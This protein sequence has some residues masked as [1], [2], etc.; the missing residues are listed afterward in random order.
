MQLLSTGPHCSPLGLES[1]RKNAIN[2]KWTIS[3]REI[4]DLF[5]FIDKQ[6]QHDVTEA[7]VCV[8]AMLFVQEMS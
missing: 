8:H 2:F 3:L 6:R 7:E 1:P 4:R 5:F